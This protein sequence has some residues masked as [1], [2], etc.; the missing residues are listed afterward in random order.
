MLSYPSKKVS[1]KNIDEPEK[2]NGTSSVQGRQYVIPQNKC[3]DN[4]VYDRYGMK[5]K[6]D[7]RS[8]TFDLAA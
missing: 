7:S 4:I 8:H 5:R 2:T 1:G 3:A 6:L